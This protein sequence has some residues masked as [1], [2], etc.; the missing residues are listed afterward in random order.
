MGQHSMPTN[1]PWGVRAKRG[2]AALGLA[3]VGGVL[4][5]APTA[6][7]VSATGAYTATSMRQMMAQD[8]GT[9]LRVT[10]NRLTQE[11]VYLA[12]AATGAAIGG[13]DAEFK[14]AAAELDENS[15]AIASGIG[16]VYG[17]EAEQQFLGLWRA[18]IG[19]FADYAMGA[20]QSDQAMKQQAMANLEQYRMD[21]DTLLTGANPNLPKGA[22]A[23][24]FKPH[25]THLTGAI[26]AQA[27]GNA[28][29]AY[30]M[31]HTAAHQ[32][33][34]I[35]DPLVDAIV[36]QFPERFGAAASAG[37]MSSGGTSSDS[38]SSGGMSSGSAGGG[39]TGGTATQGQ[40]GAG[41]DVYEGLSNDHPVGSEENSDGDD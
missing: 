13:R 27:A 30:D 7:P 32:S 21:V 34:E 10:L 25:V 16:S 33:R 4:V 39:M 15:V 6:M 5:V 22:V 37:G 3:L 11:H 36:A 38:M 19:F 31:L 28:P 8:A 29:M 23:E 40:Q 17:P 20:A 18:H 12:G 24:L 14:A 2:L 35:T 41:G 26:D 9:D 1:H